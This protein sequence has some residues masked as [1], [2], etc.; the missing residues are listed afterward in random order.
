MYKKFSIFLLIQTIFLH[1]C[2]PD[3]KQ[4]FLYTILVLMSCEKFLDESVVNR[5]NMRGECLFGCVLT[6]VHAKVHSNY[7][8]SE[9]TGE[10]SEAKLQKNGDWAQC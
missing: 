8:A 3:F 7:C 10:F 4:T 6:E 5:S 2:V 9:C 1:V